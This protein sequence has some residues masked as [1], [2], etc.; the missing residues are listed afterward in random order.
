LVNEEVERM[1]LTSSLL[2]KNQM[3]L[4][5]ALAILAIFFHYIDQTVMFWLTEGV[6]IAIA[7]WVIFHPK[8]RMIN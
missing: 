2:K 5:V 1:K 7:L 8:K 3:V 4:L 6:L